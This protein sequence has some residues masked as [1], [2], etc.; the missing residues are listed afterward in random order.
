MLVFAS[1][2]DSDN[3]GKVTGVSIIDRDTQASFSL[4][5]T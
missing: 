1:I 3:Q 5:I 2:T 4:I